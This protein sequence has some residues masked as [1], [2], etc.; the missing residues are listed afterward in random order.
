SSG[1]QCGGSFQPAENLTRVTNTPGLV[2]S[3]YNIAVCGAPVAG[4]LNSMSCGSLR[5][6]AP[7]PCA[8]ADDTRPAQASVSSTAMLFVFIM[9]P[10]RGLSAKIVIRNTR[11]MAS[12]SSFDHLVGA[13]EERR[14]YGEAE[15]LRGL[16]VDHQLEL[17]RLLDR[18]VTWFAR[19]GQHS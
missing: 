15:R 6:L 12:T 18:K 5:T 3:P 14:R 19:L 17:G 8:Y 9:L 11:G 1:C 10:Y 13:G 16:E 4:P 2:G 7:S